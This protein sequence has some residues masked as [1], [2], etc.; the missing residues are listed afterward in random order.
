MKRLRRLCLTESNMTFSTR[1]PRSTGATAAAKGFWRR[2]QAS[3]K[4]SWTTPFWTMSKSRSAAGSAIKNIIIPGTIS[5]KRAGNGRQTKRG[6]LPSRTVPLF[7]I[8]M[9][10]EMCYNYHKLCFFH[11]KTRRNF[12]IPIRKGQNRT[13]FFRQVRKNAFRR[14]KMM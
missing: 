6:S 5:K 9:T 8:E 7:S 4:K 3:P 11:T 12:P 10:R 14:D 1:S 13:K 2:C